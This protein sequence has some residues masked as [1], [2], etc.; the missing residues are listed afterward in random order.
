MSEIALD[1]GTT[2]GGPAT[3]PHLGWIVAGLSAAAGVIHLIQVP[4]HAGGT[5]LD[6]IGFAAVGWFQLMVAAV[7][8]SGRDN[9]RWYAIAAA[10]NAVALGLWIW[11]RTAGLPFGTHEGIAEDVGAV[12]AVSAAFALGAVLLSLRLALVSE[13][14]NVGRMAP[15]LLA[16]GA[17]GLATTVLVSSDP[18]DSS[19]GGTEPA[20]ALSAHDQQMADIDAQRCDTDFNDASYWQEAAYLGIDTYQGGAMDPTHSE[21]AAPAATEGHAHG[22]AATAASTTT[23]TTE[24]DP[25]GGRGT[26]GLDQLVSATS[27]AGEGEGAAAQLVI[28][29]GEASDEDY[30]AWLWWLKDTGTLGGHAHDSAASGDTGHGGHIG[31]QPWMAMTDQAECDQLAEEIEL[32]TA[33]AMKYPTAQDAMDAGWRRV[34]MYVPGIAAHYMN[35]GLVDGT[36]A[37]DEPEM[38]LY[39]GNEPEAHVVG[40]SYYIIQDGTA[41]P[42]QGFTGANDQYHRH[43]GLCQGP[44]G[45]IGD[46][47]LTAE[48]CA[49]RG[50]RKA[51][52]SRGWMSHAWVV[53]GCESPWGV[54]SAASPLLDGQLGSESGKNDG[55]CAGAGVRDR[56][57]LD[58]EV[59]STSLTGD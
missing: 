6:P 4:A 10:G 20:A 11:S 54:F 38:I 8:L 40:L 44:G 17:L 15:A 1:R 42:T 34:T 9:K 27:T 16:V 24:P 36:F 37:V 21:A 52:G 30:D 23:T 3:E 33:T 26:E 13:R 18:A 45:V 47:T 59:R 48:E 51:D 7:I 35:F 49:A 39:D 25:T 19:H 46:S 53:P 50:G 14:R 22:S 28:R 5:L 43:V 55:G 29:L 32:A 2:G 31:P 58:D 57:N 12:D 41:A 56:Y